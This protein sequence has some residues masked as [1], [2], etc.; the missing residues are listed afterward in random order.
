M[1]IIP[2][3]WCGRRNA[4]EF[5]YSGEVVARPDPVS[6]TPEEWRTYLYLRANRADWVSERWFHRYGCRRYVTVRRHRVSGE[7]AS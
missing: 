2:C 5:G 6:A 1:L 7:V 3:P 4:D